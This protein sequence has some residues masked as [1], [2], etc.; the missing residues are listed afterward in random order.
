VTTRRRRWPW[1]LAALLLLAGG[2]LVS[3]LAEPP[4]R[5]VAAPAF[6]DRFRAAEAR[7]QTERR[8]LALP[9]VAVAAA[10]TGPGAEPSPRQDPFLQALPLRPGQPV[11]VFEANALRHS[12]LGELFVHC[13]L[14]ND[15]DLFERARQASGVDL[16]KDVDRVAYV[17]DSVVVSG[18]F[19]Q[20]RWDRLERDARMTTTSYGDGA[21]LFSDGHQGMVLG[22]W[23]DQLLLFGP[24]EATIRQ[25][26]DQLEGRVPAAAPELLDDLA[27]GEV[28][29]VLPGEAIRR[30]ASPADRE[31]ADR[32]AAAASRVELHV[33]AMQDVAAVVRVEGADGEALGDLAR[34]LGG[35]LA[36]GRLQAKATGDDPLA[37]LLDAAKVTPGEGRFSLEVAVPAS[38]LE[39]WFEGCEGRRQRRAAPAP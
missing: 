5:R 9:A 15:P 13:A 29:G 32:L 6:P 19:D 2:A 24:D 39:R 14:A 23:R 26:V 20:A 17:G 18:F 3:S 4:Q 8:T 31:L 1:L 28:Y 37:D 22:V 27:Y 36:A 11:V 30:L 21:R 10:S 33:D 16:L 34:T 25:S 12:R 38:T 35:A 7:R